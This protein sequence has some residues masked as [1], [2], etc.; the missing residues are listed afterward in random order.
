YDVVI[1]NLPYMPTADIPEEPNPL[2]FEPRLALDGGP[3]GLALY[4]RL[5]PLLSSRLNSNALVLL[6]AAPPTVTG[7]RHLAQGSL[8]DFA[9]EIG[10]DYAALA[11]YVKASRAASDVRRPVGP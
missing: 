5:L 7:L 6:E 9:V 10:K 2:A 11:R 4:R 1:A 8:N 3:D